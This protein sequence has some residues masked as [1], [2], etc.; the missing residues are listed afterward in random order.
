MNAVDLIAAG[1]ESNRRPFDHE[2]DAEP[3][4]HQDNLA[5]RVQNGIQMELGYQTNGTWSQQIT[6]RSMAGTPHYRG[7]YVTRRPDRIGPLVVG[8][9]AWYY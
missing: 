6:S 7:N 1:R 5:Y 4:N 2:S 8:Y 9:C 3:L